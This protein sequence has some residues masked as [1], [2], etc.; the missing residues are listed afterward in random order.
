MRLIGTTAEGRPTTPIRPSQEMVLPTPR[1]LAVHLD[2][3]VH[4]VALAIVRERWDGQHGAEQQVVPLEPLRPDA[5]GARRAA[6]R[7]ATT[8]DASRPMTSATSSGALTETAAPTI[9]KNRPICSA[10][11]TGG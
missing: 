2:G 10:K 9:R 1:E 5:P 3:A 8:S 11:S 6:R 7:R 4:D